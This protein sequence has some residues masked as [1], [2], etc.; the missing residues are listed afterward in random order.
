M[1]A[2]ARSEYD[3]VQSLERYDRTYS[4]KSTYR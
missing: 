2:S 4:I 3:A 1:T